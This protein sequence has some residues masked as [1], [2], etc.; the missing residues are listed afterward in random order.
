MDIFC[1]SPK[2]KKCLQTRLKSHSATAQNPR[3]LQTHPRHDHLLQFPTKTFPHGIR[4]LVQ[5]A[6]KIAHPLEIPTFLFRAFF[7]KPRLLD[8]REQN[9]QN[10]NQIPKLEI[11]F[12][13]KLLR[14]VHRLDVFQ[15][16]NQI[17][18]P[19]GAIWAGLKLWIVGDMIH[20]YQIK[21]RR[22]SASI[23]IPH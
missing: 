20:Q 11:E 3:D 17:R 6:K 5:K 13:P 21:N 2:E 16:G 22:R 14:P 23:P 4:A 9:L 18:N 8:S 19:R 10:A 12:K 1:P 7:Q 15:Q